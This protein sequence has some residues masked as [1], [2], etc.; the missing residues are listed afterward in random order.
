MTNV[1]ILKALLVQNISD[2]DRSVALLL[3]R[4]GKLAEDLNECHAEV[5][6]SAVEAWR[7]P[8]GLMFDV[9]KHGSISSQATLFDEL[10]DH[11]RSIDA[12]QT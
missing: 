4:W 11:M 12:P 5:A 2:E 10:L 9:V 7:H 8:E 1:D 3:N 6:E